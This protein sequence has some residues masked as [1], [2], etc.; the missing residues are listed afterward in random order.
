MNL[1]HG[2]INYLLVGILCLAFCPAV[3]SAQ[4]ALWKKYTKAGR[5]ASEQGHYAEAEKMFL[6]AIQVAEGVGPRNP[7]LAPSLDNLA[8]LYYAQGK[9]AKA[10]TLFKRA[11][12]V[13]GKVLGPEHRGLIMS[14][15]H[16][17]LL[18]WA[19][20]RYTE[21]EPLYKQVLMILEKDVGPAH[22]DVAPW[23]D[24]LALLYYYKGD[25]AKAEPLYRRALAIAE[26]VLGPDHPDMAVGL[27]NYAA[28]LRK[29]S[30]EL[31]AAKIEGRAKVIRAKHTHES[32]AE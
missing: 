29:T 5:T 32:P 28:L 15:H 17:A 31:E 7:R 12:A 2:K 8:E 1:V 21:A 25:Y 22:S 24:T 13:N 10:E 11:L 23:L 3:A 9:Y 26:E 4:D 19:Q 6:A 27:E 14:L 30:R 18:Y 20:G 16:L